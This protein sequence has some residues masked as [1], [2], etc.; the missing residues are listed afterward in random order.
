MVRLKSSAATKRLAKLPFAPIVAAMFGLA[1]AILVMATPIWLLESAVVRLGLPS[2]LPPTAPPLGGTARA[3]LTL[4]A[5]FGTALGLWLAMALFGRLSARKRATV[6]AAVVSNEPGQVSKAVPFPA[7]NG[8]DARRAPIFAEDE[9]GS[10][11]MSAEAIDL[12]TVLE[13]PE[14][15]SSPKHD[16]AQDEAQRVEDDAASA[17]DPLLLEQA[18]PPQAQP[19]ET[20]VALAPEREPAPAPEPNFEAVIEAPQAAPPPAAKEDSSLA[21]MLERLESGLARR[22]ATGRSLKPPMSRDGLLAR[23][24][25]QR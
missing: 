19:Q 2:V 25:I 3:L 16:L 10:P 7:R 24:T 9:L 17:E 23:M 20:I 8:A 21:A 13:A 14:A 5:G 6:S 18:L 4:I 22:V 1:A 11:L 12:R 15:E